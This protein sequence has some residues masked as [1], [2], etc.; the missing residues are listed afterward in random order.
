MENFKERKWKIAFFSLVSV[1]LI[2][3]VGIVVSWFTLLSSPADEDDWR[4]EVQEQPDEAQ[5]HVSTTKVQLN[6]LLARQTSDSDRVNYHV[7]LADDVRTE[8][9]IPIFGRTTDVSLSLFPEVLENGDLKL[10][11]PHFQLQSFQLPVR[12]ALSLIDQYIDLPHWVSVL[13]EDEAIYVQ[14]TAI[15]LEGMRIETK[16]FDLQNDKIEFI[17]YIS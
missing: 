3:F 8:V 10:T 5:F 16:S 1:L 9:K 2:A 11:D 12:Q 13:P 6:Q 14:V 17:F 7:E 15:D 4:I